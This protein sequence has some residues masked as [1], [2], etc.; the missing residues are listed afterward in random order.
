MTGGA[1]HIGAESHWSFWL[2]LSLCRANSG[3]TTDHRFSKVNFLSITKAHLPY[4]FSLV[5]TSRSVFRASA[6]SPSFI[7]IHWLSLLIAYLFGGLRICPSDSPSGLALRTSRKTYRHCYMHPQDVLNCLILPRS[8]LCLSPSMEK[9]LF[10]QQLTCALA[11]GWM[12]RYI[13]LQWYL[14]WHIRFVEFWFLQRHFCSLS[15]VELFALLSFILV[16]PKEAVCGSLS[17][18][19][20]L[21]C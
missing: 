6:G 8:V 9:S 11:V 16:N 12:E 19:M 14:F 2:A 18:L 15:T 21:S 17:L 4:Q 3:T 7:W 5:L 1:Y 20:W 13:D 10:L